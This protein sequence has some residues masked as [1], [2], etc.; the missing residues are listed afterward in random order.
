MYCR[1]RVLKIE[2]LI[3]NLNTLIILITMKIVFFFVTIISLCGNAS[4]EL[5]SIN[6]CLKTIISSGGFFRLFFSNFVFNFLR[7]STE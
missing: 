6:R 1:L 2:Y 3:T 5:F 7:S 4:I